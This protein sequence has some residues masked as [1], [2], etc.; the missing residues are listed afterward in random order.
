MF[1]GGRRG[2]LE[3]SSKPIR[4]HCALLWLSKVS[5]VKSVLGVEI[6]RAQ[7]RNRADPSAGA[8]RPQAAPQHKAW[9]QGPILGAKQVEQ[10]ASAVRAS[11]PGSDF[12]TM[13]PQAYQ[14]TH[15][16]GDAIELCLPT[17]PGLPL[18]E[19]E[20][21]ERRRFLGS[22]RTSRSLPVS[23]DV[24]CRAQGTMAGEK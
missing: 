13:S 20:T 4:V 18:W 6:G 16:E 7:I 14:G 11:P 24:G 15:T 10:P 8:T 3:L 17:A 22:S 12:V 21:S 23:D 9:C 19:T 2:K 1:D 5:T